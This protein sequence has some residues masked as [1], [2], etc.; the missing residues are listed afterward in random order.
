M[1]A[2]DRRPVIVATGQSIE[3]RATVSA[4]DLAERA[5]RTALDRVPRLQSDVAHV[6][7]VNIISPVGPSPASDLARR[8]R[9]T[10]ARTETTTVGG[11]SPQWLVNRAAAAI[12]A[13][14]VE[15]VLIAG[16]EAQRSARAG[17]A[18][19]ARRRGH[20][21]WAT[22]SRHRRRP[23]AGQRGRAPGRADRP[24]PLYA[25]FES[26]IAHRAGRASPSSA[27]TSVGSWPR[28][29]R[30]PPPTPTPGS[31]R[32]GLRRSCQTSPPTTA[33]WPSPTPSACAPCSPWTRARPSSSPRWR[34]P[35]G[36]GWP[37]GAVFC[38][39]GA[40][41][42]RRLVPRGAARPGSSPGHARR[43][44]AAALE[45]AGLGVDDIAAFDI[46]SCFPCAVELAAEALGIE[47]DDRRP[48]T[49]TGGLPYFGGPGQQLLP[50]RRGHHGRPAARRRWDRSRHRPGLVRHQTRGRASTGRTRRPR[51]GAR[52]TPP[53]PSAAIDAG[54][55][56]RHRG[57]PGPPSSWRPRWRSAAAA[58]SP[59]HR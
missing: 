29:P 36:P 34:R 42:D 3:R 59:P 27:P 20:H 45:A 30:W 56:G 14:D 12:A 7:V 40:E 21:S 26:V 53:P 9:L 6:S 33:S 38:W 37:T 28:S 46:Y 49:V 23:A 55:V 19:S 54:A 15:V 50:A 39:S 35:G 41:C 1:T 10:P 11:N 52:A 13:G 17:S 25:L 24:C 31:P 51:G 58:R 47:S 48:L 2:D 8:L 57:R 16:A 44:S 5:A 4:L 43:R 18:G 32:S 22:R